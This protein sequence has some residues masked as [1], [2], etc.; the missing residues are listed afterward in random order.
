MPRLAVL[1]TDKC[2]GC[3]ACMFACSRRFG[4]GGLDKSAIH[5]RSLGGFEKGFVVVVC[6]ACSDPPCAKGCPTQALK[7]R[8][9]GGVIL[10]WSKCIGCG[11]CVEAC[12]IGAVFWDDENNKPLICVHCG[13]CVDFCPYGVITLE[14]R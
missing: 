11:L 7:P 2:V 14:E 3:Q 13:Y 8:Q 12:P 4:H 10:I 5:V 9:G 1:D 6:R